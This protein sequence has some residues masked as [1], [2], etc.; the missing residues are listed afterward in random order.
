M[1]E[2]QIYG[3]GLWESLVP[4]ELKLEDISTAEGGME[5]FYQLFDSTDLYLFPHHMF[6]NDEEINL[7]KTT[8]LNGDDFKI[9]WQVY[10]RARPAHFNEL[11]YKIHML[12]FK[13]LLLQPGPTR[14]VVIEAD[15]RELM[16]A[17]N[18]ENI[19]HEI[20]LE[21]VEHSIIRSIDI[22]L[23]KLQPLKNRKLL[24]FK[25]F[26]SFAFQQ[27]LDPP[28]NDQSNPKSSFGQIRIEVSKVYLKLLASAPHVNFDWQY[29]S[30][31]TAVEIRCYELL[32]YKRW[33]HDAPLRNSIILDLC[34]FFQL[35][36]LEQNRNGEEKQIQDLFA[37]HLRS[38][39]LKR[40]EINSAG[41]PESGADINIHFEF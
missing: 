18:A 9:D 5:I 1:S 12:Y 4:R 2:K 11:V 36:P 29:L 26:N 21:A 39:W 27:D 32:S 23:I 33:V 37:N 41:Q 7:E 31:L 20:F 34:E 30:E 17:V 14:P 38:G 15:L 22:E 28:I 25:P 10:A 35:I 13:R 6:G 3:S 19:E 16:T 40:V 24:G 8:H